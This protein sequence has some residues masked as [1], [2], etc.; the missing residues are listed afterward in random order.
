[1]RKSSESR[2]KGGKA[3]FH[4]LV[5]LL[6]TALNGNLEDVQTILPKVRVG[7]DNSEVVKTNPNDGKV[8]TADRLDTDQIFAWVLVNKSTER[9]RESV[10][11][12]SLRFASG[13]RI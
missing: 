13:G 1:M 10:I 3:R 2:E 8:G 5:I 11:Q 12:L 7:G 6:D 4:P 9:E